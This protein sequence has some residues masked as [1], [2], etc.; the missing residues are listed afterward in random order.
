MSD[1]RHPITLK[2]L[3]RHLERM[4]EAH[5]QSDV[6]FHTSAAGPLVMDIYYPADLAEGTV[7]PAVL[8]VAGYRDVG[9]P[10]TLGCRFKEMA[11]VV[12]LAQLIAAS[13][14]AAIAYTTND[15]GADAGRV[16]D[17][18]EANGEA[19]GIDA[20]RLGVWA[21]SG[22]GPVGLAL[23][24]EKRRG[25]RAAVF[26]SAFTL[27]ISGSAVADA[28]ATY[29]FVNATAGK[30]PS[31]LPDGVPL[32]LV[33]CGRDEFAGLNEALDRFVAT[34][35]A[36]GVPLTLVNHATAPHAFELDDDTGRS[37][38]ILDAMLTFIRV[39]LSS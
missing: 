15:P 6:T 31:D 36:A 32:F 26:S 39:H 4:E 29:R 22:N 8:I 16:V 5:V 13:G 38:Y 18:L 19:L 11:L 12:S 35:I 9:V 7:V 1:T 14:T 28:A 27:D 20:D 25:I 17:Y 2:K 24:M 10:L 30:S 21:S 23:V 37:H 34:A 3:I 33:R